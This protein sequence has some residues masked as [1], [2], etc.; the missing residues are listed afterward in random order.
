MRQFTTITDPIYVEPDSFSR[1]DMFWINKIRDKRDLPFISVL[2][3]ITFLMM[4]PGLSLFFFPATSWIWWAIAIY[5]FYINNFVFKGPYGLMLHCTSHRIF[6][7]QKY[8]FANYYLP[9][10][11]SPFFGQTPETYA[12]HHLGMHHV[13]NNLEDDESSTMQYQRDSF[14]DFM[15]YF[16]NFLIKGLIDTIKYFNWRKRYKLRDRLIRGEIIFFVLCGA[17]LFV[18]WPATI[19]VFILPF[20]I[21]RFIMM[22]GNFSQ[23]S[24]VDFDDPGNNYK[25]SVNCIN[26]PYNKKCWNDG[27][28]ID[29]HNKPALHWTLYPVH[30]R[31]N[32]DEFAKNK[33]FVFENI[34]FLWVWIYLMR[35]DYNKLA[36]HLINI[37]GTFE[38]DEEAINLMKKRTAKMPK[39]GI[40]MKS[41]RKQ[42]ENIFID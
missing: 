1:Y 40:T 32:M 37:N 9:W 2:L 28:H 39:R 20:F 19:V 18:H 25:N 4:L 24:F 29:H 17:L 23:H 14:R 3:K 15:K 30:F 27:Y 41:L 8:S 26:T 6:F 38:S 7:K 5:Y 10:I 22:L 36:S 31:E 34:D 12:S 33:A 13:E 21:S 16:L 35:K 11:V 42:Q